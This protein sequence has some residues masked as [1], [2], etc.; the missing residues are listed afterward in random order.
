[1]EWTL[2]IGL[3]RI[4]YKFYFSIILKKICSLRIWRIRQMAKKVLKLSISW[5]IIEHHEQHFR[6][7]LPTLDMT[8]E[9][10]KPSH[11]TVPLNT[12]PLWHDRTNQNICL[13]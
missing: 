1:M 5:L 8:D 7:S 9:A 4:N 6:F 10:K 2:Y 12:Y 13:K 11:T 3:E